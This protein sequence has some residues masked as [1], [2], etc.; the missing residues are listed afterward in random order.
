MLRPIFLTI[1]IPCKFITATT[2]HTAVVLRS[3][4]L[5]IQTLRRKPKEMSSNTKTGVGMKW[6][7][8]F[9]DF[10]KP[11]QLIGDI[12]GVVDQ[13]KDGFKAVLE[14][15]SE[16][17]NLCIGNQLRCKVQIQSIVDV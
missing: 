10:V 11:F 4:D 5:V 15:A 12:R 14:D 17:L 6:S 2:V 13:N 16:K 1:G 7:T 9:K 8:K 3:L